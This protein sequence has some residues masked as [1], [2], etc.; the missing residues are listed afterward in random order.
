MLICFFDIT[1]MIHFEFAPEGTNVNHTF[2]VELLKRFMDAV[3]RKRG[4]LWR[5]H[6]L[7]LN[8]DNAPV[9]SSLRVS[10]FL[11]G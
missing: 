7:I 2:Y 5:D 1:G 10:Q 3:R 6:S 11:T 9:H 4:G 8:Q